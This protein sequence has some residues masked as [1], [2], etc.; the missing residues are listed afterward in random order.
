[1]FVRASCTYS[2]CF[3][4]AYD[5]RTYVHTYILYVHMLLLRRIAFKSCLFL[6]VFR[7]VGVSFPHPHIA[8]TFL[9]YHTQNEICH[10]PTVRNHKIS[11]SKLL[12]TQRNHQRTSAFP[13]CKEHQLST[14]LSYTLNF[15]F[16]D[17]YALYTDSTSPH[18]CLCCV[19]S[20]KSPSKCIIIM[21]SSVRH[22]YTLLYTH[23]HTV[24]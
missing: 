4:S 5:V 22:T 8:N 7:C 9:V 10:L 23:H 11:I 1:M 13:Y 3:R 12:V 2:V 6:R 18:T 17:I 15:Y 24:N 16:Y 19:R 20:E 21:H 14:L